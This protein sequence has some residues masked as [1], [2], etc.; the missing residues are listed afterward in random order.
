MLRRAVVSSAKT[1]TKR[2]ELLLWT[3]V[4]EKALFSSAADDDE[5]KT[6]GRKTKKKSP[7]I[8]TPSPLPPPPTTATSSS[9]KIVPVKIVYGV[10]ALLQVFLNYG[11]CKEF[12]VSL[13]DDGKLIVTVVGPA[14]LWSIGAL[15]NEGARVVNDYV[16][17]T[18][19]YFLFESGVKSKRRYAKTDSSMVYTFDLF[20]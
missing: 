9:S 20:V 11:F 8:P 18:T 13:Q 15:E 16:G 19:S 5:R 1:K 6:G 17:Y 4:V 12:Q 7:K 14:M 3:G 10:K 2:E